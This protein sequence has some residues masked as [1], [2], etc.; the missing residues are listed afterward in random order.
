LIY[1]ITFVV[2]FM[3]FLNLS[4]IWLWSFGKI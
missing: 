2:N 3:W 1:I 4:S